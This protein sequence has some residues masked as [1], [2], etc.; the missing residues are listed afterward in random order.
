[1]YVST[2][3]GATWNVLGT[4][5]PNASVYSLVPSSDG[6]YLIAFTHGRGA[7][8]ISTNLGPARSSRLTPTPVAVGTITPTPVANR[9]NR[10]TP[11]PVL[12]GATATPTGVGGR[13]G[14]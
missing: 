4:G 12:A 13:Q 5:L 10:L 9:R 6:S 8:K 14:R 3:G 2:D 1:V 7:W 11:T